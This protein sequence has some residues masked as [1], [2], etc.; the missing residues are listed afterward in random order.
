MKEI[1]TMWKYTKMIVLTS[2]TAAI[3]AAILVPFKAIPIIPGFT[4]IRPAVVVPV[5]FGI[6]FGPAG[7]W[8][9]AFG[10]LIG[11]FFGT[12]GI[13]SL[14]GFIGNFFF[15]YVAY[16]LCSHFAGYNIKDLRSKKSIIQIISAC[17][18]ASA[19]CALFI[20]WGLE[21]MQLLPFAVLGSVITVN[22]FIATALLSPFLLWILYP[23]VQQWDLLWKDIMNA[24]DMGKHVCPILGKWF[25]WIGGLGGLIIGL[26]LSTGLYKEAFFTFGQGSTSF[27]VVLLVLP[28]ILVFLAGT[29]IT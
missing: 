21:I 20:A 9:S 11:D 16:K 10:N 3:Y 6:L 15:A 5:V 29:A 25:M 18:L 26:A 27:T 2:L 7:A 1:I 24:E 4:E 13:S 17:F 22:N 23:R 28:F 12:L 14:F 19:V 8:G